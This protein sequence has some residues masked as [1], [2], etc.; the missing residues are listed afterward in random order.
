MEGVESTSLF[1]GMLLIE[2]DEA[3]A[4][5]TVTVK[6]TNV[7]PREQFWNTKKIPHFHYI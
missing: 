4:F 7:L 6:C 3:I 5:T 1:I 2:N